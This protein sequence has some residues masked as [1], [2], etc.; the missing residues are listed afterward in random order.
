MHFSKG[1]STSAMVNG[2]SSVMIG[3]QRLDPESREILRVISI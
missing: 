3:S 2:T 1:L